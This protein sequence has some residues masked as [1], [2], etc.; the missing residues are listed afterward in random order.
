VPA[1]PRWAW[2]TPPTACADA[3][4]SVRA[5]PGWLGV[6]AI[7]GAKQGCSAAPLLARTR[8][9]W[10]SPDGPGTHRRRPVPR[11]HDL[12]ERALG[13]GAP[14]IAGA[15][16][17][18]ERFSA[19]RSKAPESLVAGQDQRSTTAEGMPRRLAEGPPRGRRPTGVLE[20][21]AVTSARAACTTAAG[22]A[23][24]R[25]RHQPYQ[26]GGACGR[27][28]TLRVT[29]GRQGTREHSPLLDPRTPAAQAPPSTRTHAG[30]EPRSKTR[31]G[32]EK[33]ASGRRSRRGPV[34]YRLRGG[35]PRIKQG[36]DNGGE[37]IPC[38][39]IDPPIEAPPTPA[40]PRRPVGCA[41]GSSEVEGG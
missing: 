20:S 19:V 32:G 26:A 36:G 31:T 1:H 4:R 9:C 41:R 30:C 38:R 3:P 7:A 18:A 37:K 22:P 29:T 33:R 21:P 28:A 12:C 23:T 24:P 5:G 6:G 14:A 11:R 39:P 25:Q 15:T 35:R 34:D 16:Q 27:R 10:H 40:H 13:W 8:W 17:G 2:H